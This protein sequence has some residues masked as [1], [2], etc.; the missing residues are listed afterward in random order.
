MRQGTS[1]YVEDVVI[2]GNYAY[3]AAWG[4]GLR[5][6]DVSNP[7]QM[8]EIGSYNTNG[9]AS[10]VAIDGNY[11]YIADGN[12]GL[13]ITNISDPTQPTE[14]GF[15][16]S[17][18]FATDVAII[19]NYAYVVYFGGGLGIL[20]VSDPTQPFEIGRYYKN[21]G[22]NG[23]AIS[24]NY[25]YFADF[26]GLRVIN[27]S[28]PTQLIEVG[29]YGTGYWANS[30]A[31]IGNYAFVADREDGLYVLK[32]LG[33]SPDSPNLSQPIDNSYINENTPSFTWYVPSDVDGDP[34]HFKVE[35]SAD[36]SFTNQIPDSPFESQINPLNFNPFP[37]LP[38]GR[39][40]CSFTVPSQLSNG[41]YW[42]RVAAWDGKNY[43]ATSEEWKFTI[44][45]TPMYITPIVNDHGLHLDF[46]RNR[47]TA[48]AGFCSC[49]YFEYRD[50]RSM[51]SC[52]N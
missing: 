23:V 15:Y 27:S 38:Q 22:G 47:K 31:I 10:N 29:Y 24:G 16:D 26:W 43:G 35:I 33:S 39:G 46:P 9:Y 25:V 20:N 21:T 8:N 36:N 3:V 19:G 28:D 37:P 40:T 5:V 18:D 45:I 41:D 34:L 1:S 2:V 42:W 17:G 6:I 50:K 52:G 49:K 44:E 4:I 51:S 13:R 30:V 32:Y 11:A 12:D 7:A 48:A 14:V